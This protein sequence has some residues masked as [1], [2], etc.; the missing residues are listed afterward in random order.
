M[1]TRALPRRRRTVA[2][3]QPPPARVRPPLALLLVLAVVPIL[4]AT[5]A[6]SAAEGAAGW[7]GCVFC[8][9]RGGADALLN[10]ALFAP[11]GAVLARARVRPLPGFALAAVLSAAVELAQLGIPGRDPSPPD[12][13]FNTLGAAAGYPVGTRIPSLLRPSPRAA[14]RLALAW[15]AA[16]AGMVAAP[17]WLT[18]PAPPP[19]PY[20]VQ[21]TPEIGDHPLLP[22]RILDARVGGSSLPPGPFAPDDR[23][24]AA[25]AKGG[26]LE[27]RWI[28]GWR[29]AES[30]PLLRIVG[31]GGEAAVEVFIRG[32]DVLLI[33]RVRGAV[34]RL[35]RPVLGAAGGIRG[36]APGDTVRLTVRMEDRTAGFANDAGWTARDG[37]GAGRGWAL[38]LA[39]AG[40]SRTAM[41]LLDALW[42]GLWM[43]PLGVWLRRRRACRAA[44]ALSIGTLLL[45]P[46][47]V[48]L[49]SAS[50]LD[51][52][53]AIIGI[54][55]G[56]LL[57]HLA[58]A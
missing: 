56:V 14:G 41:R 47:L 24:R 50:L 23:L 8:G 54:L 28:A 39:G 55:A 42:V 12:L 4:V 20:V 18:A 1:S 46:G 6:P 3:A 13:L 52:P 34:L 19:G 43:I 21:W 53:A 27:V 44:L 7:D 16:F 36:V 25:L 49:E 29:I 48:S 40:T 35:D 11:L 51:V 2:P 37:M 32:D 10:L 26:P 33:R 58:R 22:A 57:R 38:L 9:D 45:L 17:G 30:A 31:R 5:L 15:S